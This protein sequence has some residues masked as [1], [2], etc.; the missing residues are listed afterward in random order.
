MDDR[1]CFCM[2]RISEG[3]LATVAKSSE[4]SVN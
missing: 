1:N 2:R 3:P 4:I